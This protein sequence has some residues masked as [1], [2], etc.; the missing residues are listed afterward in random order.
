MSG[1]RLVTAEKM[2]RN[3]GGKGILWGSY[4]IPIADTKFTTCGT[5]DFTVPANF[6]TFVT[7]FYREH[8]LKVNDYVLN[9]TSAM[10][11]LQMIC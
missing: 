6:N 10:K 7:S 11:F 1:D 5:T 4:A 3:I 2:Y 8:R 9:L